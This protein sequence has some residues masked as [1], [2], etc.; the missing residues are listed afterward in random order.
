MLLQELVAK[1]RA[2]VT[3]VGRFVFGQILTPQQVRLLSGLSAQPSH[4]RMHN[5]ACPH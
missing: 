2:L 1:E 3:E 5:E 4:E